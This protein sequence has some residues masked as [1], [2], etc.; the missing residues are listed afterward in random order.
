MQWPARPITAQPGR[1]FGDAREGEDYAINDVWVS[2]TG[3]SYLLP[4]GRGFTA[5]S[6]G[7]S[8]CRAVDV[9]NAGEVTLTTRTGC[10]SLPP[11]SGGSSS[12]PIAIW[13]T[14]DDDIWTVGFY[15]PLWH[16]S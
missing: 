16:R 13:G 4:A 7:Y 3:T 1:R 12:S 8:V 5:L 10:E 6:N 9:E 2:P 11:T 15:T 14:S